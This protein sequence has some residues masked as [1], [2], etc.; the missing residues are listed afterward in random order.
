MLKVENLTKIF[1]GLKAVNN[2]S[3]EIREGLIS[4][5]IGPNGA[6]K[7]TIFNM[8]SGSFKPTSGRVLYRGRDITNL[9]PHKYTNEGIARTFQIMK[10]LAHMSVIDNVISGAFFGRNPNRGYARAREQAL[11]I[12]ELTRLA[13]RRDFLAKE[14]GTPDKKR[15]ELARAL[16]TRPDLL[17]LDEVMAGLNP[18]ETDEAMDLIRSINRSGITILM[19]EHVMRAVVDLCAE[20]VVLHHGEKIS[21]GTPG[22]VMTDPTVIEVYLGKDDENGISRN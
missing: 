21:F 22:E 4:G 7:T 5:M 13:D 18:T 9:P 3:F 16:I 12:L 11:E 6:G 10:P 20:I 14:L 19:I 17:L 8:I 2:V 15:L 1:R